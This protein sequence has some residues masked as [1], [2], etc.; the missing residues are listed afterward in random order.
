MSENAVTGESVVTINAAPHIADCGA[1]VITGRVAGD[2]SG[3]NRYGGEKISA[4]SW[5]APPYL[6]HM[7]PQRPPPPVNTLASG[8]NICAAGQAAGF[9]ARH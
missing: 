7:V 5:L 6:P 1:E 8:S 3:L 2:P 9:D 4:L